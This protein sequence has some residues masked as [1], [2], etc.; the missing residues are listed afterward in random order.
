MEKLEHSIKSTLKAANHSEIMHFFLN[1]Y[2]P[3]IKL[4]IELF[5]T[6]NWPVS[7][8]FYHIVNTAKGMNDDDI[9]INEG[10]FKSY[11]KQ[12]CE[13]WKYNQIQWLASHRAVG[14]V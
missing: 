5:I 1:F 12:K 14:L 13:L 11:K 7:K 8:D 9:T 6:E 2:R 3:Y 4:I 10:N